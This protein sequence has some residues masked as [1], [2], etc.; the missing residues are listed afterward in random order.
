MPFRGFGSSVNPKNEFSSKIYHMLR[1]MNSWN[2]IACGHFWLYHL[3]DSNLNVYSG[4]STQLP[5]FTKSHPDNRLRTIPLNEKKYCSD[6]NC[7]ND[8]MF[9]LNILPQKGTKYLKPNPRE[10]LKQILYH[11]TLKNLENCIQQFFFS[12]L[13]KQFPHYPIVAVWSCVFCITRF[14]LRVCNESFGR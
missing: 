14:L 10:F 13:H 9:D 12:N 7:Q 2:F 6:L 5:S 3:G 8:G 1:Y 11:L 4:Q